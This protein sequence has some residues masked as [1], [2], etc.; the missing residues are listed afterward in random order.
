MAALGQNLLALVFPLADVGEVAGDG[1]GCSHLRADEVRAS[2]ASL[3]AFEI[4]VAGGGAALAGLENVGVHA[5]AHGAAGLAPLEASLD[6][7]LVEAFL[8]GLR[9]DVMRTGND[10]GADVRVDVISGDN[11][12][13]GA[14][15]FNAR[16]G[17]GAD[18]D[19]VDGDVFD[20][21]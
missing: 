5:E 11:F 19:A 10:H 1:C 3:A 14:E 21:R 20:G 8:F 9:L 17:A 6:E 15:I 7:N 13:G 18:E 2:S 12:C 4:A 16:V